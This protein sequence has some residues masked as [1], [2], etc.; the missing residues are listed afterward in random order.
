M[1]R[2]FDLGQ[3]WFNSIYCNLSERQR[4]I[5]Q[6]FSIGKDDEDISKKFQIKDNTVR[7]HLCQI[8]KEFDLIDYE[9]KR[10]NYRPKLMRLCNKYLE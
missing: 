10:N 4:E 3:D 1:E 7:Q 5:L 6:D 9:A 8:S 2:E